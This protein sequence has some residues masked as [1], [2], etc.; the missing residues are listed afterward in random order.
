MRNDYVNGQESPTRLIIGLLLGALILA[1]ALAWQAQHATRT[2]L[3]TATSVLKDYAALAADEFSRR[4]MGQV[5]Y[6][7]YLGLIGE[8]GQ[9]DDQ[10]DVDSG[11]IALAHYVFAYD[12]HSGQ[13]DVSIGAV[14]DEAIIHEAASLAAQ[15]GDDPISESGY[16]VQHS[17]IDTAAHTFVF[18]RSDEGIL[19]GFE[20]DRAALREQLTEVFDYS[21]LLPS[22]L[23]AGIISNDYIYLRMVDHTES[24][25]LEIGR[26]FDTYLMTSKTLGDEY[27]GIF[28]DHRID[29]AIDPEV[30]ESLVIGGLPRSRLPL[31]A[32]ILVLTIGLVVA[33]M[34]QLQRERALSRL[35]A[36]FVSE[37]SHELRTPLTQIKMFAETLLLGRVRSEEESRRSLNVINRESQRMINLVENILRF[38][39]S[40]RQTQKFAIRNHALSPVIRRVVD[41]FRPLADG[42]QIELHLDPEIVSPVDEDAIRQILLNLLD[43]AIK[44]GPTT[45]KIQVALSR[46]ASCAHLSVSDQGPGVPEKQC[47]RIWLAYYRLQRER[48]SAIAGAG[49]GLSVVRDLAEQLRGSARVESAPEG[50]ACFIVDL[51]LAESAS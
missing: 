34:R 30:A 20:V 36:D 3:A 26:Q 24:P 28:A 6:Y 12:S 23:G 7:G 11:A 27:G 46:D 22:A 35:R 42:V 16:A 4:A 43:N 8:L 49:I 51:P 48:K 13:L 14:P 45:Q 15:Y 47:D 18:W 9:R 25:L 31:L 32:T 37:V 40:D 33:A 2:H 21:A 19:Q 39:N 29:V 44:Y 38:N 17:I 10:T 5:G 50:G 41:E 1:A